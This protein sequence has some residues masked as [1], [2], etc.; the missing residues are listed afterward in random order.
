M[1]FHKD[2][3]EAYADG[4]QVGILQARYD[5]VRIDQVEH[6]NRIDDEI[7]EQLKSSKF[8]V[9]DFTGHRGGVYF[10]AGFSLG[11]DI[12]VFWAC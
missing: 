12:P 7:F 6:V 2:M 10:E 8:V 1:W 11:F 3:D 5:P 9:A 4:F